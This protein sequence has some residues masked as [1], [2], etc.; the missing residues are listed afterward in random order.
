[1]HG[2]NPELL[3]VIRGLSGLSQK[4]MADRLNVSQSLIT[5]L[6]RGERI[7]SDDVRKKVTGE[8]GLT[9]EL[10]RQLDDLIKTFNNGK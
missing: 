10:L 3:N 7:I 6:E 1:M 2:M 4:G 5:K 8:F 9:P